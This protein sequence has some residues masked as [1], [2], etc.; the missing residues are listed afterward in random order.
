MS[1][2]PR[3]PSEREHPED[4]KLVTERLKTADQEPR[5][6]DDALDEIVRRRKLKPA[7]RS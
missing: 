7:P 6:G 1:T 5:R 2:S 3:H 4:V